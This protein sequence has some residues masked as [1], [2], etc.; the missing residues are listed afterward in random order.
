MVATILP[1]VESPGEATH[2]RLR[3]RGPGFYESDDGRWRIRRTQ[4][5]TWVLN[6]VVQ[7]GELQ[8]GEAVRS[9]TLAR[10][11]LAVW[12]CSQQPDLAN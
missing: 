1:V 10:Q 12:T 11:T 6:K 5:R 3:R 2:R 9:L 4:E 8:L 7:G